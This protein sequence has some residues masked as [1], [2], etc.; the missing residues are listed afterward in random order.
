MPNQWINTDWVCR[1]I[2]RLLLNDLVCAEYF[3]KEYQKEF[4]KEFAPGATV[5]VKIPWR[6]RVHDGMGYEADAIE[7]LYTTISLDQWLRINFEWD[8]YER[9][10]KLERS[11][12]EL[13]ENY[14]EPC[15]AA[16]AEEWDRRCAQWAYQNCSNV[17]GALGTDS[18]SV[19]NFYKAR[20]ALKEMS[21]P[22]GKRAAII[23]SSQMTTLGTNITN[24]F[25]PDD[26]ITRMWKEGSIGK[27]AGASFFE[28]NSLVS[29]TTGVVAGT[30][31]VYGSDQSGTSLVVRTT[32]AGDTL[33]KGDKISLLNVNRVNPKSRAIVGPKGEKVFTITDDFTLTDANTSYTISILPAIYGPESQYQN[34]DVLPQNGATITMWP[35]SSYGTTA[36]TGTVGLMMSMFAFML[37]GAKLYLPKAVEDRGQAQDPASGL[38]IR[39]VKAWDPY[40]SVQVNRMDS[41]GGFGNGYVDS[42]A[43][44]IAMA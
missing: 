10:V 31:T 44:C 1:E 5:R 30:F 34:V 19:Q 7:R 9:A 36:K 22:K 41:L 35:G 15:A 23:S 8:D 20:Q 12:E 40:R 3:A 16:M 39:K 27:L 4:E 18:T 11:E 33:K 14:W 21:C 26:E 2:L 25:H 38:S 24:I 28:S 42:G 43:C 17:V 32:N 6:P 29:H 13:R 37:V